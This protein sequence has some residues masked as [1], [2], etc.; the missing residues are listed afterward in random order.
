MIDAVQGI[1]KCDI[2]IKDGRIAGI[3]KAGNPQMMDGVDPHMV[4]GANTDVRSAE[5]M[6]ATAGAMDVHVHFDSAGLCEEAIASGVTTMLGGG[7]GP[8]TVGITSSGTVNLGRMLQAAEAWPINFGFL[9]KGSAYDVDPLLEQGRAGA[10]GLKIHEDWG[11]MPAVIEASLRAGDELDMQV[12]IH[13][14]T[15]NESGFFEDTMAAIGGRTIHTYHSEGAGGGHAPD[16]IR[17]A[18]EANCL[19]SSTTPPTRSQST[20]STSTS[21]W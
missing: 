11:A 1:V 17:V 15:L 16:I 12:Q 13:T 2:G 6:I 21:T 14:D 4:V 20:R 8:V 5:G 19:P 7:L 18:G 3:G 10:V 9:G